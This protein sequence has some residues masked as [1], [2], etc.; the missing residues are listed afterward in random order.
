MM[1]SI[2]SRSLP[3]DK[4]VEDRECGSFNNATSILGTFTAPT[5]LTRT[6]PDDGTLQVDWTGYTAGF[7]HYRI[8]HS[9]SPNVTSTASYRGVTGTTIPPSL[10]LIILCVITLKLLQ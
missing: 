5:N 7:T 10:I 3:W 9:L 4:V 2:T 1:L 8:Y 6:E